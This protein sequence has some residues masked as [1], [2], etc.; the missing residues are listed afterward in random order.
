MLL[1]RHAA[2]CKYC[3]I[4]GAKA[5]LCHFAPKP[6]LN[7]QCYHKQNIMLAWKW[8]ECR[9]MVKSIR[10]IPAKG[11]LSPPVWDIKIQWRAMA[12]KAPVAYGP[13]N[14]D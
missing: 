12:A 3:G 14:I 8:A 4:N 10:E 13:V 5:Q 6:V 2:K 9:Q 11:C 1:G 7:E